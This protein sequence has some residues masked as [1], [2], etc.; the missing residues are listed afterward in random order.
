[1]NAAP[2]SAAMHST[3]TPAADPASAVSDLQ[4]SPGGSRR[5][6]LPMLGGAALASVAVSA[7]FLL[8]RS[9]ADPE[10]TA[11]QTP[12]SI[13]ARGLTPPGCSDLQALAGS[14]V[15]TTA[16]TNARNESRIGMRG[17]F[18][19]EI[20]VKDCSAEAT[21]T[22]VGRKGKPVFAEP[23]RPRA[24]AQLTPGVGLYAFGFGGHFELK[25]E[26]GKGVPLRV[27]FAREGEQMV[28]AWRQVGERWESSGMYGVL[29]GEREGD[30]RKIRVKR[31]EQPCAIQ[32][33]APK[34]IAQVDE[35]DTTRID[36][37]RSSCG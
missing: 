1:M 4:P 16:T 26:D 20:T 12:I 34:D 21:L 13:S 15:F 5:L 23:K 18:E 30:P 14:W 35:P 8:G 36:A 9:K 17:F 31:R 24:S 28:G 19:L 10:P 27:T 7:Y 11:E 3:G 32:C 22:K 33:A 29:V 2:L 6:L 25:N 37:C